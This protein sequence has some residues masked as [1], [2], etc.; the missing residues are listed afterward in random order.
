[1][2]SSTTVCAESTSA[3]NCCAIE[4]RAAMLKAHLVH[5][6]FLQL[7]GILARDLIES[8]IHSC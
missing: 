4:A 8:C 5:I 3:G 6:C 1:M 7:H 2:N